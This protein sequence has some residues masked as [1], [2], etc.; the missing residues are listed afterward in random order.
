[1]S[2][3]WGKV[4]PDSYAVKS[5]AGFPELEP[6]SAAGFL[7]EY[8]KLYLSMPAGSPAYPAMLAQSAQ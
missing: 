6:L 3:M 7:L 8:W 5:D 4:R 1:M 2:V